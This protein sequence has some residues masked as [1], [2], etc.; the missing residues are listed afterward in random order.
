MR[1]QHPF[2]VFFRKHHCPACGE[3]MQRQKMKR[4][5]TGGTLEAKQLCD[6]Y[7]IFPD[8][9]K[10]IMVMWYVFECRRCD[11]SYSE[12]KLFKMKAERESGTLIGE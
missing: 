5:M 8:G 7:H 2:F 9:D 12:Q 11:V 1:V 6:Y 10:D 4:T 3:L